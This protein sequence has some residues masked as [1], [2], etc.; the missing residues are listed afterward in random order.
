MQA[1]Y[2]LAKVI[3]QSKAEPI[4]EAIALF[5]EVIRRDPENYKA[6]TQLGIIYREQK[7]L[8]KAATALN[9]AL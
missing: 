5:E 2:G 7:T 4:S 1:I 8:D 3:Q 6:Y 9:Q